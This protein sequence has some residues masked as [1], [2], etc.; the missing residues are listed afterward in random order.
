MRCYIGKEAALNL[1]ITM[2]ALAD[3]KLDEIAVG[4]R[5]KGDTR[6]GSCS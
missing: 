2:V 1:T 4:H 5:R 3:K 6:V